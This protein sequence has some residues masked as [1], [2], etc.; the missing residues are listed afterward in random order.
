[1]M[2]PTA[3]KAGSGPSGFL[4]S[5]ADDSRFVKEARFYKKLDQLR[6]ECELC[7]R[8]CKVADLERGYCGVR[9]N[10]GGT[11]YTLVHSR[12][13]SVGARDPIEKKPLYHYLPGTSAFS[14]ATAGCNM[15]CRF[16]QNWQI[17]QFR[18]E[19]VRS[20][21][22]PP[23]EVARLAKRY[24]ADT[25]AYTYSEPV[26][27]CEYAHDAA[28]AARAAGVGSVIISNGYI[29]KP[30]LVALCKQ[31]TGVKIDFKGFTDEFYRKYCS[32]K[33][34]PVLDTLVNL[35][36]IGIWYE[37]VVLLIP[38]LNDDTDDL[39]DMCRWIKSNLGPDVPVHFSRFHASYKI[40]HLSDTPL[41]TLEK[42]HRIAREA[43]LHYV[44]LGNVYGHHA[45]ST[46]CP[47]CEKRLIRRTGY[48]IRVEGMKNGKCAKCGRPI[49]GV[50]SQEQ[51][52]A[53]TWKSALER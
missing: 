22:M 25:I 24:D 43:G 6:V 31:L 32:G 15:E 28:K 3:A 18:P 37:L 16:C 8:R 36:D 30:A 52:L 46:Y 47:G 42:A 4:P 44:Y 48:R 26:V 27:F 35:R 9:E 41:K 7:P 2:C 14:I 23:P 5:V 49:P 40:K 34:K 51:A 12:P 45:E 11:Y 13:C 21:Y 39:R 20:I 10:R 33:L 38:T 53:G 50:W 1:M 19:Q 29:E 17:S